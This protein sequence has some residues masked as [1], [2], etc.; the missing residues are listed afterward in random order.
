[1]G[2]G[3]AD[4]REYVAID[5]L[6]FIA[7]YLVMSIHYVIFIDVNE[8]LNF[9]FIQVVCRLAVPFFFLVSGYFAANKLQDKIKTYAYVKRILL[10]Y[11][12]YT[13]VYL[14]SFIKDN[15]KLGHTSE[16]MVMIF[17]K[18]FFLVGSY[19]HL[20]YFLALIVGIVILY[21]MINWLKWEE[22]KIL[23]V[24]GVFYGIG[25]LGNA[26]RNIWMNITVV[27]NIWEAYETL[28][29][30]TRNGIFF[31]PFLLA[32]GYCV[33]KNARKITYKR[34]WVYAILLFVIMNIEEYFARAITEH[35]GQSML[36]ITPFVVLAVFLA[37]CFIRI[38]EKLVPIGIFLRNM[39]VVMYGLHIYMHDTYGI[40]LSGGMPYG[41]PYFL[42]MAKRVTIVALVVVGVSRI[43]IFSWLKYLY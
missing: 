1:M 28:F 24:T 6:R 5:V 17:L 15:Q 27:E 3:L 43:K 39:S 33:R 8:E 13:V 40:E 38:P 36:F 19:F 20:W 22:K 23:I 2:N 42:M 18:D 25:T 34:Y 29:Q 30:T 12:I 10:M 11:I 9:W 7:A 41:F 14:P 16:E 21:I 35:S 37:A 4:K 26:Y 32:I 31:A